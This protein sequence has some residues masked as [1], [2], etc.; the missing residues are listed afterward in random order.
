VIGVTE[1]TKQYLD[2]SSDWAR[3]LQRCLASRQK[4]RA[5]RMLD[6]VIERDLPLFG[7]DPEVQEDRRLAWLFRIDLLREWGRLSEALAWTCFECEMNPD[8]VA[9]HA[10]KERLKAA[11]NLDARDREAG[12]RHPRQTSRDQLWP[13]VAG[14]REVKAILERDVIL[15][16]QEPELYQ[17][18]RVDLPNGIL[19]YGPPGC[20][21]TFI[22]RKLA[23]LLKFNFIEVKP[24]DLA[25]IYV[26]GGQEKIGE[27]FQEARENAPTLLFF[28]ELDALVPS[29]GG[30]GLGHHYSAEV[31]E[32]LVQLNECWKNKVLVI[33][34]T[35]LLDN[36][37]AAIRRPGRMDKKVLIGPPDLE[38]RVELLKLYISDRPQ[39]KIPWVNLAETCTN[40]TAAELEHIVNEAARIALTDRR[41]ISERDI[42]RRW[43]RIRRNWKVTAQQNSEELVSDFRTHREMA[44]LAKRLFS[45]LSNTAQILATR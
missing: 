30:A 11:L 38:A 35:N 18:Y 10:L 40:Y 9:A 33:G 45:I 14:M 44:N 1:N 28:D 13:G 17:R 31:N 37:D 21:K 39:E 12:V 6:R 41:T 15:P 5:L 4:D 43:R 19:F 34:A 2:D 7:C 32:F 3:K 23:D 42:S 27:L 24:S 22:A 25:S 8:N 26:H 20:G 36:I 16:L 29:R